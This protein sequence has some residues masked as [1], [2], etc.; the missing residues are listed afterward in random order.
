MKHVTTVMAVAVFMAIVS[1][2]GGET[3]KIDPVHSSMGF[4]IGHL[5]VSKST[6]VF[7][8]FQGEWTVDADTLKLKNLLGTVKVKSVETYNKMRDKHLL[9][10]DFL[11]EP[12][13]PSMTFKFTKMKDKNTVIGQV[14]IKGITKNVEW[15]VTV[16]KIIDNPR[17]KG[18]T[19]KQ[20]I[21]IRGKLNRKDFKVGET[22]PDKAISDLVDVVIEL[23]GT[24]LGK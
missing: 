9:S 13:H 3:F 20:G 23:E 14:T 4:H 10:A 2:F 22:Y 8:D 16:S 6:G 15:T 5:G 7:K 11:D 17:D 1:A 24:A 19:R 18:K 12:K 21:S